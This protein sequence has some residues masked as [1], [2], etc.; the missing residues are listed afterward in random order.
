MTKQGAGETWSRLKPFLLLTIA[1]PDVLL[2]FREFGSLLPL[3][4]TQIVPALEGN[5]KRQSSMGL[6]IAQTLRF[7]SVI[8]AERCCFG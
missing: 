4:I 1:K 2:F 8:P 3:K 7:S 6:A 5:Q